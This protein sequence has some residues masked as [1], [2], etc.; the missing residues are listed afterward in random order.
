VTKDTGI[1]NP[2]KSTPEK[3]EKCFNVVIDKVS[4]LMTGLC[5]ADLNNMY[6]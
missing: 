5:N 3:G 2:H 1:G 4:N 6:E